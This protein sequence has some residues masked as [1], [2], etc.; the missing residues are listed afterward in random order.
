MLVEDQHGIMEIELDKIEIPKHILSVSHVSISPSSIS[1]SINFSA[2][3]VSL[4]ER[5]SD[6]T[7]PPL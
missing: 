3:M 1:V 5:N 4:I 7:Y 2:S 6:E